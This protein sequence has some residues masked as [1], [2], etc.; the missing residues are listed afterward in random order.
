[1]GI[2]YL[3]VKGVLPV[4]WAGDPCMKCNAQGFSGLNLAM[5]NLVRNGV[6]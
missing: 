2:K 5:L 6:I 1:M 4:V 3:L